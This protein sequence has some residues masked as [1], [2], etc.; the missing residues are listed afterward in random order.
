M[1][2]H[3][4][5]VGFYCFSC[6]LHSPLTDNF[7]KESILKVFDNNLSVGCRTNSNVSDWP[8]EIE[9]LRKLM[10]KTHKN[11]GSGDGMADSIPVS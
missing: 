7:S 6:I 11:Y 4:L 2:G 9:S 1:G 8:V 10:S 5:Q 3:I